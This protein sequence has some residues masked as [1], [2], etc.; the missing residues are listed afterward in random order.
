MSNPAPVVD[1]VHG[2]HPGFDHGA[3]LDGHECPAV[4]VAVV[5]FAAYAC[6]ARLSKRFYVLESVDVKVDVDAAEVVDGFDAHKV[7]LVLHF[8]DGAAVGRGGGHGD[9]VDLEIG[10]VEKLL[11]PFVTCCAVF[12]ALDGF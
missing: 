4:E 2:V 12:G 10:E 8:V 9:G 1:F 5:L 7:R 3:A 6:V 11:G